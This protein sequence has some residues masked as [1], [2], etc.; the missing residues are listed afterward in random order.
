M[1]LSVMSPPLG[2]RRIERGGRRRALASTFTWT[3]SATMSGLGVLAW[4][5]IGAAA[6]WTV[7]RLVAEW[8]ALARL[9]AG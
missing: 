1:L 3:W 9:R 8:P 7:S 4:T 5:A 6:G 2:G